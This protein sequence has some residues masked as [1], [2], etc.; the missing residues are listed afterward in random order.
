MAD[1]YHQNSGNNNKKQFLR[2]LKRFVVHLQHI[3]Q[4]CIV[5]TMLPKVH[6]SKALYYYTSE[7]DFII[8]NIS[9]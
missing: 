2:I 8:I 3:L 6:V 5:L 4:T 1:E 7:L 9:L